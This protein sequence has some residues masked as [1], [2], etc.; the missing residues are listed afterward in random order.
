MPKRL[1]ID[2]GAV[3]EIQEAVFDNYARFCKPKFKNEQAVA[4]CIVAR[5]IIG[6]RQTI[7]TQ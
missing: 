6:L 4:S 2:K 1:K 3:G 5:A 7:A